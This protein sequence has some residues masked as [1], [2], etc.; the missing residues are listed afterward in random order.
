[1]SKANLEP[2]AISSSS[3]SE[4]PASKAGAMLAS[5]H[6]SSKVLSVLCSLSSDEVSSQQG[7]MARLEQAG[8]RNL[9]RRSRE[10][11]RNTSRVECCVKGRTKYGKGRPEGHV[12]AAVSCCLEMALCSTLWM[13]DQVSRMAGGRREEEGEGG[14]VSVFHEVA[15]EF[16][17]CC[18]GRPVVSR[19]QGQ[20]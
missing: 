17:A 8:D 4:R 10:D 16:L 3:T 18:P 19:I 7:H 9:C 5:A 15:D 2:S 6:K 13:A 20:G 11:G 1:M 14:V 12:T